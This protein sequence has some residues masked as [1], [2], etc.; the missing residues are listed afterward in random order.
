[1]R[2]EDFHAL[3]GMP[4]RQYILARESLY[5]DTP[6]PAGVMVGVNLDGVWNADYAIAH[7]EYDTFDAEL[8]TKIAYGRAMA[9]RQSRQRSRFSFLDNPDLVRNEDIATAYYAFCL[10][11]KKYYKDCVPSK[12]VEAFIAALKKASDQPLEIE[13]EWQKED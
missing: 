5:F 13:R 9:N 3:P 11:C 12:R 1:M 2:H 8:G 7:E 4:I 10:R 6:K